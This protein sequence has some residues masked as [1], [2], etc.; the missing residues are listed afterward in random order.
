NNLSNAIKYGYKDKRVD[1]VLIENE[2]EAILE[3]RSF[4]NEIKNKD[5]IFNKNHREDEAK[6][7]LGLGLFMVS[8]ICIKNSIRYDVY[9]KKGQNIFRYIF[10]KI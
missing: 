2:K 4:G 7:G 9:Y 1:V 6:R 10:K 8:N 5:I 3:F